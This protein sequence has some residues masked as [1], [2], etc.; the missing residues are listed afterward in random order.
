MG[1]R[2]LAWHP[3]YYQVKHDSRTIS[4]KSF[5]SKRNTEAVSAA[6]EMAVISKEPDRVQLPLGLREEDNLYVRVSGSTGH[7]EAIK[8]VKVGMKQGD[9]IAVFMP[10]FRTIPSLQAPMSF[11]S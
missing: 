7:Q 4:D 10:S 11:F 5:A 1:E 9:V 8:I 6:C 3:R 2:Y